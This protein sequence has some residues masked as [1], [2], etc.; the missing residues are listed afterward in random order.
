MYAFPEFKT[1]TFPQFELVFGSNRH[2]YGLCLLN[3][4]LMSL[5]LCNA[6]THT[7][8]QPPACEGLSVLD[9][10]RLIDCVRAHTLCFSHTQVKEGRDEKLFCVC[11]HVSS[12]A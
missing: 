1:M 7:H 5:S 2:K 10:G 12:I 9:E 6:Q 4:L 11:V 8:T 3:P